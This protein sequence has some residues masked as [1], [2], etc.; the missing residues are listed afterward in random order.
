MNKIDINGINLIAELEGLEL[1]AYKCPAGIFTIGLG[2][3]FYADGSKVKEGDKIT[4]EQAYYLFH[5]IATKFEKV[6]ND[7][8]KKPLTQNQF[9]SLFCFCYNVGITAFKN[10]TLL[11][12]V[13]I[14]PKDANIAKQF[15]R[16]NKIAGVPS[17]GLT[18]RRIKESAIYFTKLLLICFLLTSCGTRKVQKSDVVENV[19]VKVENNIEKST[20]SFIVE[21]DSSEILVIEPID[22]IKPIIIAGIEYKNA[23]LSY[24]KKKVVKN[25]T[26][27]EIVV[28]KGSTKVKQEVK[29]VKKEVEKTTNPLLYLIFPLVIGIVLIFGRK[30][31]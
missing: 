24:T 8:V 30:L 4:K 14:N 17:K 19:N 5:L 2:N 25:T 7:S 18:N 11:R 29:E 6:I 15:L 9:N 3:T 26:V 27:K 20:D 12:L 16:W 1:K 10:S 28:D 22:T 31:I 13:N 23:R 21:A